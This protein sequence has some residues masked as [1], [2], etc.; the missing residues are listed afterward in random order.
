MTWWPWGGS[1]IRASS[2]TDALID[3]PGPTRPR[4][5]SARPMVD[6]PSPA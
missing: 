4:R 2:V 3:Q 6:R 1:E 5:I